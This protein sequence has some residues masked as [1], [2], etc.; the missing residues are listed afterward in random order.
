MQSSSR[1]TP[2]PCCGRERTNHCRFELSGSSPIVLCHVGVSS[3]PPPHLRIGDTVDFAGI[4][5]ALIATGKGHSGNSHE[6]RP[7]RER[8]RQTAVIRRHRAAVQTIEE[9]H[10]LEQQLSDFDAVTAKALNIPPVE[11]ML[12]TDIAQ[13]KTI[14]VRL[15]ALALISVLP[16]SAASSRPTPLLEQVNTL[17]DLKYQLADLQEYCATLRRTGKNNGRQL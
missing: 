8:S 13:A 2:C 9:L 14:A 15:L 16:V 3:G 7:H 12:D 5:W 10:G 11:Q 4:T 1:K 17:R 6:F